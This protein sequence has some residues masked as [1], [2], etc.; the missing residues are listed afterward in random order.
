M[1]GFDYDARIVLQGGAFILVEMKCNIESTDLT[2]GAVRGALE[3]A[4]KQLP[5]GEPGL[6]FLKIPKAWLREPIDTVKSYFNDFL[7]RTSRVVA[8]VVRYESVLVSDTGASLHLFFFK[9]YCGQ[10][11]VDPTVASVLDRLE[12]KETVPSADLNAIADHAVRAEKVQIGDHQYGR[13]AHRVFV[14]M[15]AVSARWRALTHCSI[16][17]SDLNPMFGML[18]EIHHR[19]APPAEKVVSQLARGPSHHQVLGCVDPVVTKAIADANGQTSKRI[20]VPAA[21]VALVALD[22]VA[23][24]LVRQAHLPREGT[25]V[26]AGLRIVVMRSSHAFRTAHFS[27]VAS[28]QPGPLVASLNLGCKRPLS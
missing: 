14:Q 12:G 10:S 6:I 22:D 9:V 3:T 13:S 19:I 26:H 1:R 4:R 27:C 17:P 24:T 8:I 28:S 20:G 16:S 11:A 23:H 7:R 18:A 21:R 2:R 15:R 25:Q 5:K